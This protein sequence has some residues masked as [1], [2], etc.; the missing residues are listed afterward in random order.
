MM[1]G[2]MIVL[3]IVGVFLGLIGGDPIGSMVGAAEVLLGSWSVRLDGVVAIPQDG[4]SLLVVFGALLGAT[5]FLFTRFVLWRYRLLFKA[6]CWLIGCT[7]RPG[8]AWVLAAHPVMPRR[9]AGHSV[10]FKAPST[11]RRSG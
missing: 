8:K 9:L 1:I 3:P 4:L 11:S 7:S 6:V 2:G 10:H 5:A